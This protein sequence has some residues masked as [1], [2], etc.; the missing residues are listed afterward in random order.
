[1]N[2]A[3]TK[4]SLV[5]P[6]FAVS[7]AIITCGLVCGCDPDNSMTKEEIAKIGHTPPMTPAQ[8]AAMGALMAS[9][10]KAA[11]AQEKTWAEDHKDMLAAVNAARKKGGKPPIEP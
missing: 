6:L 10:G 9:G 7:L 1:M 4:L 5:K 11:A 8:R 3:G 2:C